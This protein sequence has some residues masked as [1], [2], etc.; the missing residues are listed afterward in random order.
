[1]GRDQFGFGNGMGEG[2]GEGYRPEQETDTGVYESKVAANPKA[3]EAVRIGDAIGPNKAGLT[4]EGLKQ[5]IL[6]AVKNDSDPQ[7][8]QRL[9]KDQK[10]HVREY[11]KQFE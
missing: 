8:D 3:G 11:F 5:E 10:E 6:S 2:E 4:Q 9:P 7:S 1:M